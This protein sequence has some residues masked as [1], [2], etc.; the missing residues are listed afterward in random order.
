MAA[1][2]VTAILQERIRDTFETGKQ[3]D[4]VAED[5]L[6]LLNAFHEGLQRGRVVDSTLS[7]GSNTSTNSTSS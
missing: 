1:E 7:S 4:E 6:K 5:S 2:E 3:V